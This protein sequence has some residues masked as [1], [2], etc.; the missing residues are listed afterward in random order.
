MNSRRLIDR[1]QD[2]HSHPTTP[3]TPV[4][5]GCAPQQMIRLKWRCGS[6][7]AAPL[8]SGRVRFYPDNDLGTALR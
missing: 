7:T 2:R 6:R 1:P 4:G 3:A 5:P 8:S